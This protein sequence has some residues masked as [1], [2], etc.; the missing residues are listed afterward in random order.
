MAGTAAIVTGS[1]LAGHGLWLV[2]GLPFVIAVVGLAGG[3]SRALARAATLFG[4]YTIIATGLGA[5]G[6]QPLGAA[7]LF[8]T[9]AT[10]M[11][12]I[13]LGLPSIIRAVRPKPVRRAAD[14]V[15]PPP[16]PAAKRA[17]RRWLSSLTALSGWQYPLRI[18]V[19]LIAAQV[20]GC[21]WP[22]RRGY[23]VGVTVMIVARRDLRDALKRTLQRAA[24]TALGVLLICPLSLLTPPMWAMIA[25][26][27]LLAAA[28][29]IF[30][31]ARYTVYAMVHTPAI[32]LL[33][34]FGRAPSWAVVGDR[35]VATLVGCALASTFGYLPWRK[36]LV[37]TQLAPRDST[38]P[39]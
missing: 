6:A 29:P 37:R 22:I 31:E 20:F 30:R 24:G 33:L 21:I 35:M 23:W 18:L 34:D 5:G 39:P 2:L 28:R 27:I 38:S 17:L 16:D 13:S 4:L 32:L 11:A 3:I 12:A 19:C 36:F 9:G 8:F 7:L 15:A 14:E 26:L 1:S 10:W 25:I